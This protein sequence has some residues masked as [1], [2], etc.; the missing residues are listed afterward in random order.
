MRRHREERKV[1]LYPKRLKHARSPLR[2]DRCEDCGSVLHARH[3]V[4][5][6]RACW[7]HIDVTVTLAVEVG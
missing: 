2:V 3:F 7:K 1:N 5:K 6:C 4:G